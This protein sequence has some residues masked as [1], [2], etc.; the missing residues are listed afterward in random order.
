[1]CSKL[2]QSRVE[3]DPEIFQEADLTNFPDDLAVFIVFLK[4]A[5]P[6]CEAP[7]ILLAPVK[8]EVS[9][10]ELV[11]HIR[12]NWSTNGAVCA[13]GYPPTYSYEVRIWKQLESER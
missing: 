2:A 9:D 12:E 8:K 1:V 4:C 5:K 3:S 7:V 13:G 11:R 10:G 6:D